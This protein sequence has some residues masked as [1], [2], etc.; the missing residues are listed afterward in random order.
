MLLSGCPALSRSGPGLVEDRSP[1]GEVVIE[2]EGRH[3]AVTRVGRELD[4][5]RPSFDLSPKRPSQ[6][7]LSG[8]GIGGAKLQS[9]RG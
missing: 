6:G 3:N 8:Q 9:G 5:S 4:H 2:F 1:A 7:H